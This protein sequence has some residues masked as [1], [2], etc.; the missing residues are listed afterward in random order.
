[1]NE[2]QSKTPSNV[3]KCRRAKIFDKP[4][5][6]DENMDINTERAL[7]WVTVWGWNQKDA[8]EK[9][10]CG[11]NALQRAMACGEVRPSTAGR[12]AKFTV[13]MAKSV[14]ETLTAKALALGSDAGRR[15]ELIAENHH[16][17]DTKETVKSARYCERT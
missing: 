3:E 17:R 1:V 6:Q 10:G 9:S 14:A 11:R 16:A 12:P 4:P 13:E 5:A 15:S 8:L 2:A 7:L